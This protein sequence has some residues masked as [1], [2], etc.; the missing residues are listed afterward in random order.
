MYDRYARGDSA[1]RRKG[2]DQLHP[3][4]LK[5]GHQ[6]FQDPISDI[7]VENSLVAKALQIHLQALELDALPI[8]RIGKR[9]R[10]EVGLARLR[11]N[12]SELRANDLDHIIATGI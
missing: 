11:A 2:G 12:R 9:E 5:G 8:G 10:P 7:L 6:V 1:A 3:P 4:R